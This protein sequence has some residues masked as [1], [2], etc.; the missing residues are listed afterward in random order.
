MILPLARR[1]TAAAWARLET[2]MPGKSDEVAC[3]PDSPTPAGPEAPEHTPAPARKWQE[4]QY[5]GAER[6]RWTR[7]GSGGTSSR[8]INT[9]LLVGVEACQGKA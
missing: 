8:Y 9:P 2:S 6:K 1:Y 5:V 7:S 4:E 3:V